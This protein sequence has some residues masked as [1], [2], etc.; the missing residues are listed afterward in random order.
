MEILPISHDVDLYLNW[1]IDRAR[2]PGIQYIALDPDQIIIERYAGLADIKNSITMKAGITMMAYSMT[3]TLTAV[4]VLQLVG[5]KMLG[6]DDGIE[7]YLPSKPYGGQVTIRQLLSHTGGIPNPLPLKW[8]HPVERHENFDENAA[9]AEVLNTHP[10]LVSA[11]GDR[12]RYSNIG[13][14]LLGKII[15]RVTSQKYSTYMKNEVIRRLN[16][17]EKE[18]DFV[19]PDRDNHSRGYLSKYSPLN[20]LKRFLIDSNYICVYEDNWL[21]IKNHYVNGPSYGG[22]I[23]TA[24]AFAAFLKDQL[25]PESVLFDNQTGALLN[26]QQK[27]NRGTLINMTLGW[28]IG[29]MER[30][31][32]FYK[33]GGGGG[34]HCEMRLYPAHR[35]AS[36]IMVNESSS[37]CHG[38]L[39]RLDRAVIDGVLQR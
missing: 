33:E 3:K 8:V 39:D 14:W 10:R 21:H 34:Y 12:Y 31:R 25:K 16:I 20:L 18:M 28:H 5:N 19:I 24:R 4:A 27:N 9:L 17:P 15:E 1:V 11:P 29:Q 22:L 23:G 6:L 35:V 32:Y 26:W 36:V 13:Y 7:R 37:R 38:Y 30:I 2:L